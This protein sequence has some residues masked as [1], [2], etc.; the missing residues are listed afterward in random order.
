MSNQPG[1][2]GLRGNSFKGPL[3]VGAGTNRAAS[4]FHRVRGELTAWVGC[5][6]QPRHLVGTEHPGPLKNCKGARECPLPFISSGLG[7][8]SGHKARVSMC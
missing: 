8:L 7:H 2:G 6:H 1:P 5:P 4:P 3:P